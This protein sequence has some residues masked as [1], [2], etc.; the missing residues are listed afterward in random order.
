MKSEL[1]VKLEDI[2]DK[3]IQEKE[4]FQL[5]CQ[6]YLNEIEYLKRMCDKVR[7]E[8][9]NKEKWIKVKELVKGVRIII[10]QV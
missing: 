5:K 6:E 4:A 7:I 3:M 8:G 1:I 2:C 9:E 10:M